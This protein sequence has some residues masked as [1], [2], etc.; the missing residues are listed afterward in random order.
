LRRFRVVVV[1]AALAIA[2][3]TVVAFFLGRTARSPLTGKT[4][5]NRALLVDRF[6][7]QRLLL[8][9]ADGAHESLDGGRS[10]R[11]SGL[12]GRKVV[13]LARLKDATVWA[14]GRGFLSRSSD[15]GRSWT[16]VDPSGLAG[17][18]VRALSGSRDVSGRLDAAV[19]GVGV[20]RSND[21]GR[22][23]GR[24]GVSDVGAKATA[25]A[26][27]TDGVL[28]LSDERLGVVM[29]ANGDGVEWL[30]A[31]GRSV[32]ALAPNYD[33]Q[34]N[35]VLLAGTNEG[36]LRTTNKGQT[37]RMVLDVDSGAGAVAFSQTRVGAAYA[38]AG[39]GTT[40]R[41]TDFGATWTPTR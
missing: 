25:L 26:E 33:D 1:A 5:G 12:D 37:W 38:V 18:D 39:D 6:D 7:A 41:S 16:D 21:G 35:A 14:A 23:F 8:A 30:E 29:N 4:S 40:Y 11:R 36:L 10:W 9:S 2:A 15:G 20:F 27:T 24:L 28:F 19:G 34:H 17:L 3:T 31:R 13:A 22:T 32:S